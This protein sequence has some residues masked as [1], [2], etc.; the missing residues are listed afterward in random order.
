MT[1]RG[2][3]HWSAERIVEAM[4]SW[5]AEHGAPPTRR[6]WNYSGDG[7]PGGEPVYRVFGSGSRRGLRSGAKRKYRPAPFRVVARCAGEVAAM[8][9]LGASLRHGRGCFRG[10]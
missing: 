2:K 4:V 8:T 5:A 6:D 1:P 10:L 3:G 7:H 9:D